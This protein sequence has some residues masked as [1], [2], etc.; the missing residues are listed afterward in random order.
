MRKIALFSTSLLAGFVSI[1]P[2]HAVD[3]KMYGQV[4]K[5]LMG[6]DDGANTDFAVVDNDNSSTRFGLKGE[7]KLDNGL[8]ASV[9]IEME[10]QS[11]PSNSTTQNQA[12]NNSTTPLDRSNAGVGSTPTLEERHASVGLAGNFGGVVLGKTST[13]TD[14]IFT[15]DK[16]G[17]TDI[18]T[19]DVFRIG[20]GLVFRNGANGFSNATIGGM[21]FNGAVDRANAIRYDSPKISGPWGTV[22]AKASTSQGGDVDGSAQYENKFGGFDVIAAGGIKL[23]NDDTSTATNTAEKRY[24]AAVSAKHATGFAGTFAYTT[25]D[26]GQKTATA[27]DPEQWYAKLS[28]AW[29]AYEVAADYGQANH[30]GSTGVVLSDSELTTYGVGAQYNMGNGV[31]LAGMYRNYDAD[32]S[33]TSLQDID[34]FVANMR[35]KF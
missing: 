18:M 22:S 17:V 12:A 13:A 5:A 20:G 7:Q 31:S 1:A 9:L 14:G 24:M 33:G 26:L 4:N 25:D 10:S 3:V 35:V 32:R 15:K 16:A 8:T 27:K 28:Y 34:L 21:T 23:N 19:S 2:A 30:Y 6:Y 11:N 29:D